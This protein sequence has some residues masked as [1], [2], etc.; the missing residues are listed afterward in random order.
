MI[1]GASGCGLCPWSS[2][3]K[4]GAYDFNYTFVLFEGP[5]WL[6]S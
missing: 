1:G 5:K 4:V 2:L 3:R 6:G